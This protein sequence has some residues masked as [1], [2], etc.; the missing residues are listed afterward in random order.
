[1]RADGEP[2]LWKI[3]RTLLLKRFPQQTDDRPKAGDAAG[4]PKE[5]EIA[6]GDRDLAP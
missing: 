1:M 6:G 3:D 5:A 2:Y 4:P